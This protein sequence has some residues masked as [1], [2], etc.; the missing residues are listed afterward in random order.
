[1]G[2]A[3]DLV[4][5]VAERG[6]ASR[7]RLEAVRIAVSEA[8]TNAVERDDAGEVHVM[9]SVAGGQLA[10]MVADEG[11]ERP[12]IGFGLTLIAACSDHFTV[13]TT[14]SGGVQVDMRFDLEAADE[15][16]GS[17]AAAV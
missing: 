10:V 12:R 2:L 9:A 8:L 14:A 17:V 1:M 13:G 4:A 16:A 3:R 7:E 5:V 11:C 6:G 15:A